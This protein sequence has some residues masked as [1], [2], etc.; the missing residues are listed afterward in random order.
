MPLN[1]GPLDDTIDSISL[2]EES[3]TRPIEDLFDLLMDDKEPSKVLKLGRSL[4]EEL[5]K[6]SSEFLKQNLDVFAWANSDMKGIDSNVM[7]HRLNIDPSKK[8]I[9]QKM[10]PIVA[11]RY[12]ALKED[13]DKLLS[14]DFIKE[15]FYPSWLA[16][17]ILVKNPNDKWRICMDFT[18]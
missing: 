7:S 17:S 3:T 5:Q 15:S 16:N 12:Q 11:E 18:D 1:E 4:S 10:S 6:V 8:P 14:C 9:R 2:D 13:V